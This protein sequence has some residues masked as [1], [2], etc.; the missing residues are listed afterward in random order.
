MKKLLIPFILIIAALF[1]SC[2]GPRGPVGPAGLDGNS[3]PIGQTFE[4]EKVNF[5]AGNDW[6]IRQTFSAANV[7]LEDQDIILVYI[8]WN[9]T[10]NNQPIWRLLPQA[11]D[12][13]RGITYNFDFTPLD[14][15][16]FIDAPSTVNLSTLSPNVTQNQ[17]FRIVALPANWSNGRMSAEK[18]D[19]SDYNSV[20]KHF[21][22]DESKIKKISLN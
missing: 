1:Q 11:I 12:M 19:Y 6:Q 13:P 16:V 2:T 18:V 3:G 22:L 7:G 10:D 14:Y 17:T 15:T 5:N 21:N 4:I 20:K 8:L 9:T